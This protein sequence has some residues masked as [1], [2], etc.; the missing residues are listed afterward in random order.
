MFHC[1]SRSKLFH[2]KINCKK[3]NLFIHRYNKIIINF[4]SIKQEV[5]DRQRGDNTMPFFEPVG[6]TSDGEGEGTLGK[7][8]PPPVAPKKYRDSADDRL[9]DMVSTGPGVAAWGGG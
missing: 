1:Y 9:S 7:K 5:R 8:K 2:G 6:S 4:L 3:L